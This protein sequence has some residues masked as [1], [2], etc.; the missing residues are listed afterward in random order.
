ME[1]FFFYPRQ[2]PT[3][4]PT[5]ADRDRDFIINGITNGFEI[6][7]P[8]HS[9]LKTAETNNYKSATASDVRDKV[10]NQIREEISKGNYVVTHMKPT[11]V[12]ALGAI[13]KPDTDKIR[14]IHDCSRP[15][16]SN[17]N[18]YATTQHFSYVTVEKAASQIKPSGLILRKLKILEKSY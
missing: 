12:S 2:L 3:P 8:S 1:D 15:Q 9:V 10:E 6:Y 4:I 5:V 11:I 14:L 13:P 18:S 7:I 17:V 16:F